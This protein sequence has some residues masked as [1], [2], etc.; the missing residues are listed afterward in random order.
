MPLLACLHIPPLANWF[1]SFLLFKRRKHW[2]PK[3]STPA[4]FS[5]AGKNLALA[6]TL[7]LLHSVVHTHCSR[8][9]LFAPV[10]STLYLSLP[11]PLPWE[12]NLK[13]YKNRLSCL[14]AS[15]WVLPME[16]SEWGRKVR[17]VFI[18]RPPPCRVKSGCLGPQVSLLPTTPVSFWACGGNQPDT[19]LCLGIPFAL[20]R[21]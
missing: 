10:R 20:P 16:R 17:S 14:L 5:S 1:W 4:S 7:L 11:C 21:F 18:P 9:L 15:D 12:T 2:W 13:H 6:F 8:F 19:A 3:R